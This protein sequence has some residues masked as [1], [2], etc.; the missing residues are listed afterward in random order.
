MSV[1]R[2]G[3]FHAKPESVDELAA[4]LKSIMPMIKSSEGCASCS[5]LQSQSEPSQF[6]MIEEWSSVEAHKASVKNIPPEKLRA[7]MPLLASPPSG[8]Y[9]TRLEHL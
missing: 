8:G 3:T 5:L 9:F 4:F 2:V 1:P 6:T 7:I